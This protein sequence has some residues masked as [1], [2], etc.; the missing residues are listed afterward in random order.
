MENAEAA[1][2]VMILKMGSVKNRVRSKLTHIAHFLMEIN[3][4]SVLIGISKMMKV[5]VKEWILCVKNIKKKLGSVNLALLASKLNLNNVYRMKLF[6]MMRIV[7]NGLMGCVLSVQKDHSFMYQ[8]NVSK[9]IP[10]VGK[11]MKTMDHAFLV[12]MVSSYKIKNVLKIRSFLNHIVKDFKKESVWNVHR[13]IT[14]KEK[15][16]KKSVIFVKLTVQRTASVWVVL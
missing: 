13:G 4:R 3:V 10:I 6:S 9:L 15:N 14:L 12:T 16:V 5:D 2:E 11:A 1:L 8:E 7:P